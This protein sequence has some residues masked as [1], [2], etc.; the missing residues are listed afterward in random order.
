MSGAS[1]QTVDRDLLDL[2]REVTQIARQYLEDPEA[3]LEFIGR[4]G[5]GYLFCV[6]GHWHHGK[7]RF[8][9]S[10]RGMLIS[11]HVQLWDVEVLD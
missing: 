1:E 2:M 11:S 7:P 6:I 3:T 4:E 5:T 8:C 10:R 9:A